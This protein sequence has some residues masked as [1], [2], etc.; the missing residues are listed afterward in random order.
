MS[1]P[2]NPAIT[3]AD[4]VPEIS[5]RWSPGVFTNQEPDETAIHALFEAARWAP[6]SYNEQP[7][8]YVYALKNDGETRETLEG[9]LVEANA[10]AKEAGLLLCSFAKKTFDKNGKVNTKAQHDVGAS[11]Y[12]LTL[13][14]TKMGLITHQMGGFTADK[15]NEALGVPEN[16]E[17]VSMMAVGYAGDTKNKERS[18]NEQTEFVRRGTY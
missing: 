18:R 16:F 2:H 10:W 11:N 1:Y 17:P 7:W 5:K 8:L 6:S 12:A 14:A 4:L 9:L 13:Q 15:A 3:D